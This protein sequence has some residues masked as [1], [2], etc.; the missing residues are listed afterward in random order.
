MFKPF[1]RKSTCPRTRYAEDDNCACATPP[2]A[3]K[4]THASLNNFPVRFSKSLRIDL[5]RDDERVARQERNVEAHSFPLEDSVI[6]EWKLVISAVFM[7]QHVYLF[8]F[9]VIGQPACFAQ[10]LEHR[11]AVRVG[12]RPL[13]LYTAHNVDL[14]AID[15]RHNHRHVG[16]ANKLAQL[17][18]DN[19][20]YL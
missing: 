12:D 19:L 16:S 7:P 11:H 5:F 3:S 10:R 9:G 20:F 2:P 17:L 8:L 15:C 1:W 4:I 14:L 13:L 18:G 6:V